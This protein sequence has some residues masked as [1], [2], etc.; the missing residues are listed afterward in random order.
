MSTLPTFQLSGF[1]G[2]P[3]K[4]P[5]VVYRVE[6]GI[7]IDS[8]D[9]ARAIAATFPKSWRVKAG[10]GWGLSGHYGYV[11]M[12]VE[13]GADGV[14]GGANEAGLKRLRAMAKRVPF[15]FHAENCLNAAS[16]EQLAALLEEAAL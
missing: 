9:E 6:L 13:L 11:I 7:T 10:K 16:P 2:L 5:D 8:P 14:N 3:G 15:E 1:V 12:T 4:A